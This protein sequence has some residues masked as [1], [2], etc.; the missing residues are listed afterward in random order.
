M[1][2]SQ[3]QGTWRQTD[4][5]VQRN[6]EEEWFAERDDVLL[7]IGADASWQ[8]GDHK[9]RLIEQDGEMLLRE[10]VTMRLRDDGRLMRRSGIYG[11]L[12]E[13]EATSYTLDG[14]ATSGISFPARKGVTMG[15]L[16]RAYRSAVPYEG[17][18]YLGED[19]LVLGT[20]DGDRQFAGLRWPVEL[21]IAG[22][23]VN[24]GARLD[25]IEDLAYSL[26]LLVDAL[27]NL[28]VPKR[29]RA[30]HTT[31]VRPDIIL[32]AGPKVDE[33]LKGDEA[34]LRACGHV[35]L[36]AAKATPTYGTHFRKTAQ[37]LWPDLQLDPSLVHYVYA[38][39]TLAR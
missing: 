28:K 37:T 20:L 35:E 32:M 25:F 30:S 24:T 36:P 16:R 7:T 5:M 3:W 23:W 4:V 13:R 21:Q 19:F 9:G 39:E 1:D 27:D 33:D 15:K 18:S 38:V 22:R 31:L 6:G 10:G 29:T 17:P 11:A 34:R 12:F 14:L 2:Q 26:E 8:Q